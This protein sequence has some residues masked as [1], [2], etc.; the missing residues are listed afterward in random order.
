[1]CK[2]VFPYSRVKN[3]QDR[4]FARLKLSNNSSR[5]SA[6]RVEQRERKGDS[7]QKKSEVRRG[8]RR[9]TFDGQV[10][11]LVKKGVIA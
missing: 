11:I 6:K 5:A 7:L 9:E 8:K 10:V 2:K 1:M 3:T 4:F